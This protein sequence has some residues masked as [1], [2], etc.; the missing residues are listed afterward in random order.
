[1]GASMALASVGV[2]LVGAMQQRAA[3][4][5]QARQA[6]EQKEMAGL[7]MGADVISRENNLFSI[8]ASL[9]TSSASRGVVGG[10]T[11]NTGLRL[12]ENKYSDQDIRNIKIMGYSNM[13]NFGLSA[14]SAK[15]SGRAAMTSALGSSA[16]TIGGAVLGSPGVKGGPEAGTFSAFRT[17]L[18]KEF[19]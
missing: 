4:R 17:Q 7:Q 3:F 10:P 5:M 14:A 11:G 12:G 8:L 16:G 1:M 15:M 6:E 9:D 19:T 2:T 13:R 18:R